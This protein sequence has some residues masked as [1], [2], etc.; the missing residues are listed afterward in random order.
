MYVIE[1]VLVIHMIEVGQV[2]A[3]TCITPIVRSERVWIINHKSRDLQRYT[4]SEVYRNN[5]EMEETNYM[6]LG[7]I[8]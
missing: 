3:S 7:N 8:K 1:V 6:V 2:N 5:N 4:T